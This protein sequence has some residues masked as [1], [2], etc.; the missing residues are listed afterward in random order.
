MALPDGWEECE[1]A[2]GEVYYRY[3]GGLLY[4]L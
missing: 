4:F 1:T 3:L 2:E